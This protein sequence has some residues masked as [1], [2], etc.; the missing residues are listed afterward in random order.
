LL[1]YHFCGETVQARERNCPKIKPYS[2]KCKFSFIERKANQIRY[3]HF[4][5]T[6]SIPQHQ[7]HSRAF[8]NH[9]PGFKWL[10]CE[11]HFENDISC[12]VS[13]ICRIR[14]LKRLIA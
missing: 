8:G 6:T 7:C 4:V 2:C 11:F 14:Y 12:N 10:A 5:G 13:N 9:T 3:F 1:A